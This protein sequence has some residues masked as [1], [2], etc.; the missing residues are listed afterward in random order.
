M[1]QRKKRNVLLVFRML[2][3]I[4]NGN[5]MLI[6]VESG[7]GFITKA[8]N[9]LLSKVDL[10]KAAKKEILNNTINSLTFIYLL[11]KTL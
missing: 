9:K 3:R 4:D 7:I 1:K 11:A 6:C 5:M 10:F 2:T 8:T